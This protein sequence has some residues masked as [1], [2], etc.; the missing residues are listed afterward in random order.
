[1]LKRLCT[2]V[3]TA[4]LV[5]TMLPAGAFAAEE[6]ELQAAVA[7]T[8]ESESEAGLEEIESEIETEEETV[9][10]AIQTE[11][12]TAAAAIETEEVNESG[13]TNDSVTEF[14][15]REEVP[16]DE[17]AVT[18]DPS[19][20]G[21]DLTWE[22]Q[23][24]VLYISGSGDMYD[25]ESEEMVPWY[26]NM[27]DIS[28]IE[29]AD[30]VTAIGKYV[31]SG[32]N[33]SYYIVPEQIT[34][35]GEYAFHS[36][37]RLLGAAGS[38]AEAFAGRNGNPFS[39]L[40]SE[41]V[42]SSISNV[43]GGVR[44]TWNDVENAQRY[45]VYR[46]T[47]DT[48]WEVLTYTFITSH[49]DEIAVSGTKYYYTVQ[50]VSEDGEVS[51]SAY[52][53]TGKSITYVAAP[54]ISSVSAGNDGVKISWGKETGAAKYRLYRKTG[55]GSWG[56]IADTANDTYT[57]TTAVTG[58][59]YSYTVRCLDTA[60]NFVS[61][62][63]TTGKSIVF[64]SKPI[65][66]SVSNVVG[67]VK[68]TWAKSSGAAK[69]RVYRKSGSGS[70][71][72]AGDTTALSFTDKNV[73]SGTKYSYTVRCL[74]SSGQ[75]CSGF[76]PTGKSITYVAAPAIKSVSNVYG[77]VTVTWSKI[78]G[79]SKYRVYRKSG[80]GSWAKIADTTAVSYTDKTA[81]SGTKYT[82]TV[83]CLDSSG[84]TISSFDSTGKSIIYVA[85]PTI[86]SV[87]NVVGGVK[88]TWGK[89]K[90]AA[91]YR[92][93]RKTGSGSWTKLGDTTALS[94]GDTTAV[95]GTK[96]S[97]TVRCLDSSGNIVSSF[98]STGKSITYVAA[99]VVSSVSKVEA[100]VRVSWGKI[101]GAAKYRVYRKT[102]SGSW[103]KVTDTAAT[104]YTDKNVKNG[105]KYTYT[106]RCLNSAGN[107]VSSFD[108]TGKSITYTSESPA[109]S[110]LTLDS[111]SSTSIVVMSVTNRGNYN[112]T[113]YS[114]GA[115]L[116]DS[117][118]S[119]FN[120]YLYLID[121]DLNRLSSITIY[122][123]GTAVVI[124]AV[125]GDRTWYDRKTKIYYKFKYDGLMYLGMSS[126]YYGNYYDQY[127][128]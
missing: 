94:Y 57:D 83:R 38:E 74:D 24:G 124:F 99:P 61:A 112:L 69:Y 27:S 1:M 2:M 58:T 65:I 107:P 34:R 85:A 44:I 56:K 89:V 104:T 110:V 80:S 11:E 81:A 42:I 14:S 66:S 122:P 37:V 54:V 13:D 92:V 26:T 71:A 119:S 127:D 49:I 76:D 4:A 17:D 60:G 52:D 19:K 126:N 72:K 3:L 84:N 23:D 82:Y 87:D 68:V 79:A 7:E 70:W 20:C 78:T 53:P 91:R 113:I 67:G 63:D 128:E 123:G 93:Y 50:C 46:K 5:F 101:T 118:L 64:A 108:S 55:N 48:D 51:T 25:Y 105:I 117:S 114:N 8:E 30:G 116:A 10:A 6:N 16:S 41:P 43:N 96:Y 100:G 75:F 31:F 18:G 28:G 95:S 33:L 109:F 121:E 9:A 12:E 88:V 45:C 111:A 98:H 97:Y 36:S 103:T 15:T 102:G 86:S 73:V 21:E 120:R 40:V 62:Y 35:I 125:D 90:G 39:A 106:V 77:G 29:L 115:F 47:A 59:T 22:F 32:C